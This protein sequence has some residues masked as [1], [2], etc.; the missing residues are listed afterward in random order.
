MGHQ[1]RSRGAARKALVRVAA[2]RPSDM[3]STRSA[4]AA[5]DDYYEHH[6]A[7][8]HRGVYPIAVEATELYEGARERAARWLREAGVAVPLHA[9]GQPDCMVEIS[10]LTAVG[11]DDLRA[12]P[13]AKPIGRGA[14]V[15]L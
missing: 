2:I 9:N 12:H 13:P 6:R 10:A 7:S 3:V 8:V 4:I 11:P 1:W 14:E 15:L 5:M